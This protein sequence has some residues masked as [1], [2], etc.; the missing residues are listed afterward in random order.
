MRSEKVK[1]SIL[2]LLVLTL[3]YVWRNAF[4]TIIPSSAGEY[5][6]PGPGAETITHTEHPDLL[7]REPRINPFKAPAAKTETTPTNVRRQTLK[8]SLPPRPAES[9]QLA[10]IIKQ[11][12]SSQA[13]IVFPGGASTIMSIGD[14][15]SGWVLHLVN[16]DKIVF[17]HAKERD[18]LI[19]YENSHES[20]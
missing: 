17:R 4:D 8:P 18:T 15:L 9:Y 14:S 10:G 12:Q 7:F 11:G 1:R 19:Y 20:E 6:L 2:A 13:V 5:G 3:G 16:E